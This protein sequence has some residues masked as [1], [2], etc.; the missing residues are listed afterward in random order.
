[1]QT[2][3]SSQVLIQEGH[4]VDFESQHFNETKQKFSVHEK[5]ITMIVY[6]FHGLSKRGT[7]KDPSTKKLVLDVQEGRTKR[8]WLEGGVLYAKGRHMYVPNG[9]FK[10]ELLRVCHDALAASH[11]DEERI[12]ALL[13]RNFYWLHMDQDVEYYLKTCLVCQQDKTD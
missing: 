3:A 10:K 7:T 1:M 2:D 12:L 5:E 4:P 6:C 13:S 8:F 11:P 9:K